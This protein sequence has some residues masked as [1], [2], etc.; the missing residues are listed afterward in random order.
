MKIWL[1]KAGVH[2]AMPTADLTQRKGVQGLGLALLLPATELYCRAFSCHRAREIETGLKP[3]T[4]LL[5][6]RLSGTTKE[7][8]DYKLAGEVL[9]RKTRLPL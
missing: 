6:G 5:I 8:Q 2:R 3:T 9:W 4:L 1:L 7:G